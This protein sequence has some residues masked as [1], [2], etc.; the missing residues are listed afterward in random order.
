V[1]GFLEMLDVDAFERPGWLVAALVVAVVATWRAA[2]RAPP[3]LRWPAWSEVRAAGGRTRDAGRALALAAR[4][5]AL[6]LLAIAIGGP[7]REHAA[8]P[9][10]GHGLDLVLVLDTSDSMQALDAELEGRWR[11]RLELARSVVARFAERRVAEG[12]RVGLVVFGETAFTQSPLAS[13]PRLLA[14][15]LA[16]VAPGMAGS[17][18]AVGDGLALAVKRVASGAEPKA[19]E[20]RQDA[21]AG[22][23]VV[24]LTDGRTNAGA[25]PADVAAALAR[26]RGVRVHTVG[27]GG[28]GE[29]PMERPAG[30]KR[31]L[32]YERH[33]LDTD[34]LAGI[35]AATGGRFFPARSSGDLEAV[36]AAIDALERVPRRP[37]PRRHRSAHPEPFLAGAALCLALEIAGARG[38]ARRIP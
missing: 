7:V 14:A 30:G 11:T 22:R 9:E 10:P 35:A 1:T 17:A 6:A 27:I 12:D 16:R 36:Y 8:P 38:F 26:A 24:L 37:P 4:A 33:D 21:V 20:A 25:V 29:V 32:H 13:D 31:G 28:T 5:A 2:R 3:A 19:G 23:L 15:A 34:T 18:T